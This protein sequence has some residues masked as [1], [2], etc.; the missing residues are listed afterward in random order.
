MYKK[1][2]VSHKAC[3]RRY[4]FMQKNRPYP[5]D[6]RTPGAVP[7]DPP[8]EAA[9]ET[10]ESINVNDAYEERRSGVS[11]DPAGNR[12]A[13]QIEVSEDNN[14][15]RAYLRN[16]LTTIVSFL[17]GVLE[18]ILGL[19]FVF[20]LLGANESSDFVTA[21][22]NFSHVF[23]AP[24]NGIFNDQTIG[25]QSVFELSTLVAML[26]YALIG[27]GLIALIRVVLFP[28]YNGHREVHSIRKLQGQ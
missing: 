5:S 21:L 28:N 12:V 16:W 19:R 7:S 25:S 1:K 3:T 23:V 14:M 26:I 17:L 24:F 10:T 11:V 15:R 8:V 6:P 20:R 13:E 27:W 2:V 18:V 22:Y 4:F 9:G